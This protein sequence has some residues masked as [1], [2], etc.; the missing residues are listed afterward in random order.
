MVSTKMN[1]REVGLRVQSY[2]DGELDERRMNGIRAH[3]A[4]CVDCGLEADVFLKIKTD[5]AQ[6]AHPTD[7]EALTRL[8]EFSEQISD[9]TD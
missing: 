8:R 2:L 9:H 7:V 3:L 1:C 5:L 4:A 6:T